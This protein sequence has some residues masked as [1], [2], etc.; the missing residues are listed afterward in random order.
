[1]L[2]YTFNTMR[3]LKGLPCAVLT[4]QKNVESSERK[5]K[6]VGPKR[7]ILNI[8]SITGGGTISEMRGYHKRFRGIP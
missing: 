2:R 3:R 4:V 1:M 5:G 7:I 8:R 6:Q